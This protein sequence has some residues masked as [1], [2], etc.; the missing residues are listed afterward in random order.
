MHEDCHPEE[1]APAYL[2]QVFFILFCDFG[3]SVT[4]LA[5][6]IA[7]SSREILQTPQGG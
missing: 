1:S 3:T 5:R 2:L 4:C 7:C 6:M